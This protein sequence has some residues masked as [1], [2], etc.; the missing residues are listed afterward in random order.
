[1]TRVFMIP[2]SEGVIR[3]SCGNDTLE[4][5][6]VT[7]A[8]VTPNAPPPPPNRLSPPPNSPTPPPSTSSPPANPFRTVFNPFRL[9]GAYIDA[10]RGKDGDVD[11]P[12]LVRRVLKQTD[13]PALPD[14]I[15]VVVSTHNANLHDVSELGRKIAEAAPNLSFG[16]DFSAL[17]KL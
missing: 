17:S 4:I 7:A 11:L 2:D 15:G 12:E 13:N 8:S 5:Q 6:I 9:P 16:L 10:P 3:V 14:P 1:M